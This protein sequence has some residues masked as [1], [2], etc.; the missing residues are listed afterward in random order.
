MNNSLLYSFYRAAS[1]LP[2]ARMIEYFITL[3]QKQT[4]NYRWNSFPLDYTDVW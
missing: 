1:T 2:F 4:S 3:P